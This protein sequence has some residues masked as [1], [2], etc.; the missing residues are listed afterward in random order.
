MKRILNIVVSTALLLSIF[1]INVN[2]ESAW[3]TYAKAYLTSSCEDISDTAI[4]ITMEAI[5]VEVGISNGSSFGIDMAKSNF[6]SVKTRIGNV[7]SKLNNL[8]SYIDN[9]YD[10]RYLDAD[11]KYYYLKATY[12]TLV[13]QSNQL[14]LYT[15]SSVSTVS[16]AEAYSDLASDINISA[17]IMNAIAKNGVTVSSDS[18]DTPETPEIS[19]NSGTTISDAIV[20]SN[21]EWNTRYWTN[22]NYDLNCYNK[23]EVSGRGYITFSISKPYD[24]KGKLSYYYLYLYDTKG[25]MVWS[26]Y[27]GSRKN[28]FGDFYEYKIG[29][30]KGTYYMDID[31]SFYISSSASPVATKCKYTFTKNDYWEIEPNNELSKATVLNLGKKYS[32]VYCDESGKA[33]YKDYFKFNLKKG[34]KYTLTFYN[35]NELDAGTTII[36]LFDPNGNEIRLSSRDG[37]ESGTS[38]YWTITAPKTGW[39]SLLFRN[40][41]NEIGVNYQIKVEE[42]KSAKLSTTSYAYNGKVK[43][44]GVVV[45]DSIGNTLNKNVDYTVTYATGRKNVGKYKVTVT[46]KGNYSGYKNLYFT[47][48][49]A[50]TTVKSLTAG[51]KSLKVAI[52]KKST[53]VT[54]YQIQYATNKSFKSAKTKN[55]TSYKTTS[56]TLSK[57]S[58]KKTYYVRVR[59]YKTVNG[60]KYYSGW[61]SYKYK[62]T[63]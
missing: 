58:A 44:P 20:L 52:T 39:H 46:F 21:G 17:M 13:N 11:G 55:V 35:Y 53:Q 40:N 36:D 5:N 4:S 45:K 14:N 51:K 47:I 59:T 37:K 30:A 22:K 61:S 27:T 7:I 32:G 15:F 23:I 25:N 38:K 62:K 54:G 50:K 60:V 31:P 3:S 57:L 1:A 28:S 18:T 63:K 34:K 33:A 8:K 10:I 29:L 43:S 49:P 16:E 19:G 24:S 2:A 41:C 9:Y 26:S 6:N 56:V 42:I 12:S 48:N